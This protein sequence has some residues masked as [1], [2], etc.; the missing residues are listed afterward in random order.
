[1]ATANLRKRKKNKDPTSVPEE[2]DVVGRKQ[3]RLAK[4]GYDY[5]L[6]GIITLG[7]FY[8]HW[9]FFD[10][11]SSWTVRSAWLGVVQVVNVPELTVKNKRNIFTQGWILKLYE[12]KKI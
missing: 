9:E 6:V 7:E 1:M 12:I 5:K 2:R 4:Y 10:H 11:R 3:E 8:H